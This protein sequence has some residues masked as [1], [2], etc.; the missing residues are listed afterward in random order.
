[1]KKSVKT[2]NSD[3]P[4]SLSISKS[5]M[6]Q[7]A[8]EKYNELISFFNQ[9]SSSR[10]EESEGQKSSDD[11]APA[12]DQILFLY[13][14][15]YSAFLDYA[16]SEVKQSNLFH[17]IPSS[18]LDVE[19]ESAPELDGFPIN[20]LNSFC[21]VNVTP[22]YSTVKGLRTSNPLLPLFCNSGAVIDLEISIPVIENNSDI[23]DLTDD[24]II[25]KIKVNYYLPAPVVR[26][27]FVLI[28]HDLFSSTVKE[29]LPKIQP[30]ISAMM[31]QTS[32]TESEFALAKE[33]F[34]RLD[35][36]YESK[37]E[38]E[39]SSKHSN[40]HREMLLQEVSTVLGV[41][42]NSLYSVNYLCDTMTINQEIALKS[43]RTSAV[44]LKVLPT[45]EAIASH[46]L[47]SKEGHM[48]SAFEMFREMQS[49]KLERKE[50]KYDVEQ[51]PSLWKSEL[52][53]LSNIFSLGIDSG[54][55][56]SKNDSPIHDTLRDSL[57]KSTS[58]ISSSVTGTRIDALYS[59]ISSNGGLS[60]LEHIINESPI[61]S[62]GAVKE[63]GL[64][65]L[66]HIVL[67]LL[68]LRSQVPV[69]GSLDELKNMT[70]ILSSTFPKLGMR[71]E[72]INIRR[73]LINASGDN[74]PDHGV[75]VW[76]VLVTYLT[77]RKG[78]H[79]QANST[80]E[81][82]SSEPNNYSIDSSIHKNL[83]QAFVVKLF[84]E[85]GAA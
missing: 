9:V 27:A 13:A 42:M 63:F 83:L 52:E 59:L 82:S 56:T 16:N 39:N 79:T 50:T 73:G 51:N 21:C 30:F 3:Q 81:D 22:K 80:E 53:K 47:L 18:Y 23:S 67:E 31:G 24:D 8:L 15:A 1:M 70:D 7:I 69:D 49:H 74:S 60:S 5:S 2:V 78:Q 28:I 12:F 6:K 61:L 19:T 41:F 43:L 84:T 10:N 54:H 26:S 40:P 20:K 35:A 58:S 76:D 4:E 11:I 38:N 32:T 55:T 37:N 29:S 85:Y 46:S 48:W 17:R 64:V 66:F 36:F 45:S 33:V 77:S 14:S 75:T 44:M 72:L 71:Q 57:L 25:P 62:L 65:S 34:G 68:I